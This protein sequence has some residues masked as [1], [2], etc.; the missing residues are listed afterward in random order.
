MGNVHIELCLIGRV[1]SMDRLQALRKELGAGRDI[2]SLR[3]STDLHILQQQDIVIT[4]TSTTQ[5]IVFPAHIST[6]RTVL[7]ADISEPNA[8]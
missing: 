3:V 2:D 1:G 4:L 6:E 5:P 8:V 7:V